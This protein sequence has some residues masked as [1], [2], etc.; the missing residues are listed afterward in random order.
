MLCAVCSD[1]T[2]SAD[3]KVNTNSNGPNPS[4]G[5]VHTNN[6]LELHKMAIF[7]SP[8]K[9]PHHTNEEDHRRRLAQRY[10]PHPHSF[11]PTLTTFFCHLIIEPASA[12]SSNATS[13]TTGPFTLQSSRKNDHSFMLLSPRDPISISIVI[14]DYQMYAFCVSP[15]FWLQDSTEEITLWKH[16]RLRATVWMAFLCS[17]QIPYILEHLTHLW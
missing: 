2:A 6:Q 13:T 10:H 7:W 16:G 8:S 3:Y 9:F 11:S 15:V 12:S 1:G 5:L 14:R 17:F 4:L